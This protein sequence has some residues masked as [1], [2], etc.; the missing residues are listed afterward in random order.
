MIISSVTDGEASDPSGTG[1]GLIRREELR[2]ALRKLSPAHI[3]VERLA[4]LDG[5]V[6]EHINR[7]RNADRLDPISNRSSRG[8][9]PRSLKSGTAPRIRQKAMRV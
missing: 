4:L 7:L 2:D 9:S 5:K 8:A 3:D 6:G 1:F